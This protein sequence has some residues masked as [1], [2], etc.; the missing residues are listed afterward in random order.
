[1]QITA[2]RPAAPL[3]AVLQG[4]GLV[5]YTIFDTFGAA[6]R[7]A[8]AIEDRRQ[9]DADDLRRLGIDAAS[10]NPRY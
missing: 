5:L 8:A 10:F 7:T 3:I 6:N 2:T 4:I 9:P 1:M